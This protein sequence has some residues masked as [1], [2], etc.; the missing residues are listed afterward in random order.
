MILI[1]KSILILILNFINYFKNVLPKIT[2][3][4]SFRIKMRSCFKYATK[5]LLKNGTLLRLFLAHF[6]KMLYQE[7]YF[8]FKFS[9]KNQNFQ[10]FKNSKNFGIVKNCQ[11]LQKQKQTRKHADE[12]K[13]NTSDFKHLSFSLPNDTSVFWY[14]RFD[15]KK[16]TSVFWPL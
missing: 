1:L 16:N 6:L 2:P 15:F 8:S 11:I 13:F 12:Q 9:L 10:K 7:W 3:I 4:L 5:S 14:L